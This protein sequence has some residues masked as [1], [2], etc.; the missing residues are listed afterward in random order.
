MPELPE[1]EY[2]VRRLTAY[3]PAARIRDVQIL[4]SG[5]VEPQSVDQV[6][7]RISGSRVIGYAR[8]AKNVLI[9]L[10][11]GWSVR[12]QLGMTGH[13]YWIADHRQVPRFTRVLLELEDGAGLVFEDCR[14]FGSLHVHRMAELAGVFAQYGPEP[15]EESFT[16]QVLKARAGRT[17]API[18]PFLLDQSKVAGLGNIWAAETLFH[19][20]VHP[21]A[22]VDT[23]SDGAWRR[24]HAAIRSTLSEAIRN[25]DRVTAAPEDFPEADLLHCAVYGRGEQPC[26]RCP[27]RI[28]RF[29]QAG[30]STFL[31]PRCQRAPRDK[32]KVQ[33]KL[34]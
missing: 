16:W 1:A 31:C 6:R 34:D 21:E 28:R 12:I 23:L 27:G 19:A 17:R 22:R 25:T 20:R 7:S 8:R 18:K 10:D 15:L 3:A 33:V 2:M 29:V 4:R 11:Q 26:R 30:R 32:N 5:V 14:M 9:H 24:V 13:V